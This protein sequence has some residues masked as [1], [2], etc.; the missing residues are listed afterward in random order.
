M[1][2][3]AQVLVL[4]IGFLS[5]CLA[6]SDA[7]EVARMT[8]NLP[9]KLVAPQP[10]AFPARTVRITE[11][12]AVGDGHT[13]NTAAF[14]KA[15]TACAK[16][17]GGTVLVPP[18]IWLTGPIQLKSNI[19]LHLESGAVVLFT[20]RLEDY[21]VTDAKGGGRT[22]ISPIS[23]VALENIAI[24]GEG[25]IDGSG[26][27]WRPVKKMKMTAGQW[28]GLLALNGTLSQAG[29]IWYPGKDALDPGSLQSMRPHMIQLTECR[30]VLL[31]GPTFQNSPMWNIHPL[32]CEDVIIRNITVLNP[33][34]SQNGDGLDI[35]ASRR[36]LV[37]G[38]HFDVGDDAICLKSGAGEAAR[39]RGRATE[40]I[41]IRDCTVYHGHGGITIGS[42][43]SGG[44]RN[45]YADN[46]TFL[47]T[48][49]GLRFKS[50]RG[51]GGVVESLFFNNIYM[52]GIPTDAVGFTMSYG[53]EAPDEMPASEPAAVTIPPVDEGTP[54]FRD[55][56]FKNIVCT[57]ARRAVTL[58]GLPEMPIEGIEFTGITISAKAGF[59]CLYGK[60]IRVTNARILPEAGTVFSVTDSSEVAIDKAACPRSGRLPEVE[61]CQDRRDPP[62]KHRSVAG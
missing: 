43:M 30:R 9:F 18:G 41:V 37:Y 6:G 27:A 50:T 49:M 2:W 45:V 19:N 34:Y 4:G 25:I 22:V 12:G 58:V 54:R 32:L 10:P 31:D 3:K 62:G 36:V 40:D 44:V 24:T 28:K 1:K 55:I 21:A 15:I 17:G 53:N 33:W 26:D 42:E 5:T 51:R 57:G 20:R 39:R 29:D 16:S 60:G 47:G 59:E 35:D 61:R 48:D 23:G 14:A 46:C 11:H 38:A 52:R 13:L 56:H 7:G 8:A